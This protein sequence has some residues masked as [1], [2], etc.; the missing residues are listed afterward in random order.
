MRTLSVII[1]TY[2]PEGQIFKKC[3]EALNLACSKIP[4]VEIIIIDNNSIVAINEL[5]YIKPH[6]WTFLKTLFFRPFNAF[7]TNVMNSA[8]L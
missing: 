7:R 1:C 2:N 4:S 3:L 8:K 5:E 6:Y